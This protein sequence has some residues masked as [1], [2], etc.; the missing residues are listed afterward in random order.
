MAVL[1]ISLLNML[2]LKE[3][4]QQLHFPLY[5]ILDF[6]TQLQPEQ[7]Q[8]LALEQTAHLIQQGLLISLGQSG[9]HQRS[10]NYV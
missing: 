5:Q 8:L 3:Q 6:Q 1:T 9:Q 7:N 4:L 2:S 10:C